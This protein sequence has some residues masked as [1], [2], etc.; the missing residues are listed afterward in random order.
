MSWPFTYGLTHR[1]GRQRERERENK[2]KKEIW[3][4]CEFMS[5]PKTIRILLNF[6][7]IHWTA[8]SFPFGMSCM[9]SCVQY[10]VGCTY[11]NVRMLYKQKLSKRS[12]WNC[13]FRFVECLEID[14]PVQTCVSR[15]GW[16]DH[17]LCCFIDAIVHCPFFIFCGCYTF[18]SICGWLWLYIWVYGSDSERKLQ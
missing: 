18:V 1:W 10:I 4:W 9:L 5:T 7:I 15:F 11:M 13:I 14:K 16:F 3:Y 6:I 17:F 2:K 8:D 12:N